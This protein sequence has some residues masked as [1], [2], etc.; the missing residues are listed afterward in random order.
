[1]RLKQNL[2][3]VDFDG[4]IDYSKVVDA[5]QMKRYVLQD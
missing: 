5:F 3:S 4:I 1:M 2:R